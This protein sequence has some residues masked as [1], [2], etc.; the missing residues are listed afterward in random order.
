MTCKLSWCDSPWFRPFLFPCLHQPSSARFREPQPTGWSV[1]LSLFF[2]LLVRHTRFSGSSL[3]SARLYEPA[4][5]VDRRGNIHNSPSP[6]AVCTYRQTRDP[7][8]ERTNS[9]D[10]VRATN[11]ETDSESAPRTFLAALRACPCPSFPTR[12]Q[13]AFRQYSSFNPRTYIPLQ[14]FRHLVVRLLSSLSSPTCCSS[15]S[16]PWPLRCSWCPLHPSPRPC[17][18]LWDLCSMGTRVNASPR[19]R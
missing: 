17:A 4:P 1:S 13:F 7:Q 16:P 14:D 2:F 10:P 12:R 15:R 3:S 8:E 18:L 9:G 19:L 6:P 5:T 11:R